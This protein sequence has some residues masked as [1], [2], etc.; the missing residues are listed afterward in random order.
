LQGIEL[1]E[2]VWPAFMEDGSI[3]FRVTAQADAEQLE[4]IIALNRRLQRL[5]EPRPLTHGPLNTGLAY[6]WNP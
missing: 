5:D 4:R 2:A 3:V 1:V 6:R